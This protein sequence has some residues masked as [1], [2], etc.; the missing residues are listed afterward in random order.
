MNFTKTIFSTPQT[1]QSVYNKLYSFYGL[2]NIKQFNFDSGIHYH[3][4]DEVHF[5]FDFKNLRHATIIFDK[6]NNSV[7]MVLL[8]NEDDKYSLFLIETFASSLHGDFYENTS[9]DTFVQFEK[10]TPNSERK[11]KFI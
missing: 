6:T 7:S 2:E 4:G 1:E 10:R 8:D 3:F 5:Q 11:F 9:N